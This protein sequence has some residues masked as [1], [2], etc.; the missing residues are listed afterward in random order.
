MSY[1]WTSPGGAAFDLN[2][3]ISTTQTSGGWEWDRCQSAVCQTQVALFKVER[4]PPDPRRTVFGITSSPCNDSS[5][6]IPG[7]SGLARGPKNGATPAK[8]RVCRKAKP[9][10]WPFIGNEGGGKFFLLAWRE[11]LSLRETRVWLGMD[12][13]DPIHFPQLGLRLV[14]EPNS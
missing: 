2:S 11:S 6:R 1:V 10:W 5:R 4:G 12:V 14:L 7:R 9:S 8:W 13:N 3:P